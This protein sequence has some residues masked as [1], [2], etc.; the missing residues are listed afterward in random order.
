MCEN[1]DDSREI[2]ELGGEQCSDTRGDLIPGEEEKRI[3]GRPNME[4]SLMDTEVDN[5]QA[6]KDDDLNLQFGLVED[7]EVTERDLVNMDSEVTRGNG[8][9][10]KT[11]LPGDLGELGGERCFDTGTGPTQGEEKKRTLVRPD[12]ETIDMVPGTDNTHV[13][14]DKQLNLQLDSV[15]DEEVT[16]RDITNI[17]VT[18]GNGADDVTTLY[19]GR[20]H[21]DTSPETTGDSGDD[22]VMIDHL[23]EGP[24]GRWYDRA[25]VTVNSQ[26]QTKDP[27]EMFAH[28]MQ[29][30]REQE[31]DERE[32]S[33]EK[34]LERD[35]KIDTGGDQVD[36]DPGTTGDGCTKLTSV[37]HRRRRSNNKEQGV[38][39]PAPP[40]KMDKDNEEKSH[41][42]KTLALL[43]SPMY[44]KYTNIVSAFDTDITR[45]D[46][47]RLQTRVILNEG[48]INWM[49]RWWS[50][51]VNGRFGS[52]PPPPQSNPQIPRC[53][54]TSTFWYTRMTPDGEFSYD[55]VKRWTKKFEILRHYDLM[56]IP[57]NIRARKHWVLALGPCRHRLQQ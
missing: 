30:V 26:Q 24:E 6:P 45:E 3:L 19:E 12:T 21:N 44:D 51:Q 23:T 38:Q 47:E 10:D 27:S 43:S 25:T 13:L 48:I 15:E 49:M 28:V 18:R 54:F 36:I 37:E 29:T 53:F 11:I 40:T 2:I 31:S 46:F 20:R 7:E 4:T 41:V 5:T 14:N 55:N 39:S 42:S 57:I 33:P 22:T 35:K 9:G 8:A 50:G 56:I 1:I 17:E 52:N 34:I 16:E 32:S